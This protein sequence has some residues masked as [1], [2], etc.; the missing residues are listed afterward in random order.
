MIGCLSTTRT[1]TTIKQTEK[2]KQK[3]NG[4]LLN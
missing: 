3:V 4:P 2:N 1:T